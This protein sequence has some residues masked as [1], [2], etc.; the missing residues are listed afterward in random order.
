MDRDLKLRS[1]LAG[2]SLLLRLRGLYKKI[3]I[4]LAGDVK[5]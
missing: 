5:R 3:M 4:E 1:L 2:Y